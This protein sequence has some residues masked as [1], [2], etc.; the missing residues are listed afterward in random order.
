MEKFCLFDT[1]IR[2]YFSTL[3]NEKQLFDVTLATDDGQHIQAH[4][5][6]LA[7]GSHFFSDMFLKTN[8]KNMLIYLKGITSVE[9]SHVTDFMYNGEA[10]VTQDELNQF[11]ETGR[12]LKVKGL[13][14]DWRGTQE[15][16]FENLQPYQDISDTKNE[17]ENSKDVLFPENTLPAGAPINSSYSPE[18]SLSKI[19]EHSSEKD[20][21]NQ[22][23]TQIEE[24]IEEQV[25]SYTEILL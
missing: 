8:H 7:A 15:H 18:H 12:E 21:I 23:N 17:Q 24:M 4:K 9:L 2:E 10:S 25:I 5:V 11:L 22:L 13:Q 1:N 16:G 14:G 6:V 3:R 19:D 20:S